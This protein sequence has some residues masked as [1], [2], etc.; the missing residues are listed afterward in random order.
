[1][2]WASVLLAALACQRAAPVDDA[3]SEGMPAVSLPA[4]TQARIVDAAA[5]AAFDFGPGLVLLLDPTH[6]PPGS[7]YEGGSPV[8][9]SLRRALVSAGVVSGT[10]APER[11]SEQRAPVCAA[12][13]S[14][15]VL[16][17]SELFRGRGDTV[18]LY[19][20]SEVYAASNGPGQQPFAFE[21]A[22]KLVPR[23]DGQWRVVAE[24]RV[25][26]SKQ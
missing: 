2:R 14:G 7:G 26:G 5:H 16:R 4:T 18:H 13:R 25:R 9:D 19:L 12:D 17:S 15:Y 8:P 1:M 23:G 11:E 20:A 6:L 22:Y 10:C 24:G 21:M 3:R